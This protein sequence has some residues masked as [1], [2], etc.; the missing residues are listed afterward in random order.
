MRSRLLD[1]LLLAAGL[2]A[3]APQLAAQ[4]VEVTLAE[5]VRR[6]LEV[7][8]A[9]VQAQGSVTNA[10]WQQRAA[11]GAFL[12]SVTFA[13][14]AFRQNFPSVV[15]GLQTTQGTSYHYATSL[16]ASLDLFTGLRRVEA[17]RSAAATETAADAARRR[18]T[19]Q[20]PW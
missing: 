8:P 15:N 19:A 18:P 10:D 16:T 12:P 7:Q 17:F 20:R 14:S 4:Q 9:V 13:S 5:A 6:A 2:A 11:Y 1:M 3:A